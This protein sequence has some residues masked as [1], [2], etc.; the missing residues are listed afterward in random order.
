MLCWCLKNFIN[1]GYLIKLWDT[2]DK[3]TQSIDQLSFWAWFQYILGGLE[4]IWD[5]TDHPAILS[6]QPSHLALIQEEKYQKKKHQNFHHFQGGHGFFYI[7]MVF[8]QPPKISLKLNQLKG[9]LYVLNQLKTTVSRPGLPLEAI[10]PSAF[11]IAA[12]LPDIEKRRLWPPS[13]RCCLMGTP[14]KINIEPE[15]DGGDGL[16]FR[17]FF[18]LP[19]GPYFSGSMLIFPG[20]VFGCFGVFLFPLKK[21]I[22]KDLIYVNFQ[23]IFEGVLILNDHQA[24]GLSL[25]VRMQSTIAHRHHSSS[26]ITLLMDEILHWSC[27]A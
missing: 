19:R 18:P 16:E 6:L 14:P 20:D 27:T 4:M 7:K 1:L 15:N 5:F 22:A 2:F 11:H 13:K 21:R 26:S 23:N 25:S 24:L 8:N 10:F 12:K 3:K 17:W 9:Y